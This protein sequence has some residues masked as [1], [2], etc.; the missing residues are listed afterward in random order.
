MVTVS[1]I[2]RHTAIG[3]FPAGN[4]YCNQNINIITLSTSTSAAVAVAVWNTKFGNNKR[5]VYLGTYLKHHKQ[6]GQRKGIPTMKYK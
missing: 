4:F 5:T 6:S 3:A 2:S 1:R